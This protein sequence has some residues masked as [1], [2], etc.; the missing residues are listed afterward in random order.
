[1]ERRRE[2]L[3]REAREAGEKLR[4]FATW[5]GI[6][7][8]ILGF[9][10]G[11]LTIAE[12]RNSSVIGISIMIASVILAVGAARLMRA[13]GYAVECISADSAASVADADADEDLDDPFSDDF[14]DDDEDYESFDSFMD[15]M[16]VEQIE[17]RRELDSKL[18]ILEEL[19]D[20]EH[21]SAAEYVDKLYAMCHESNKGEAREIMYSG[22]DNETKILMLRILCRKD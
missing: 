12:N 14:D 6:S 7:I 3:K 11:C 1:M 16:L 5:T 13:I 19:Y 22:T 17:R 20:K 9:Y 21:I 18:D 8:G 10:A 4:S 15:R 2:K